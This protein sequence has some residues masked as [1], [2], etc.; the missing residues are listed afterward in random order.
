[1]C[2][3]VNTHQTDTGGDS[4][5]GEVGE[6][7]AV[8]PPPRAAEDRTV[9]PFSDA[10]G[11]PSSP[12]LAFNKFCHKVAAPRSPLFLSRGT[13]A[14]G[15]RCGLPPGKVHLSPRARGAT[16]PCQTLAAVPRHPASLDTFTHR[17]RCRV[18]QSAEVP[19]SRGVEGVEGRPGTRANCRCPPQVQ[20]WRSGGESQPGP[21]LKTRSGD[22]ACCV[23]PSPVFHAG[24]EEKKGTSPQL[25]HCL[26]GQIQAPTSWPMFDGSE[27]CGRHSDRGG[28]FR[29]DGPDLP[30]HRSGH[31]QCL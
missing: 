2:L 22:P 12:S 17:A 1:M 11:R 18:E 5:Q 30:P 31:E 21:H 24:E 29:D 13:V 26:P 15:R 7:R 9:S 20:E 28:V 8:E 3:K 23:L 16:S 14:R 4:V 19:R 6:R 27:L 10:S 25:G